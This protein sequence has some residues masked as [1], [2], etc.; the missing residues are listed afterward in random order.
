MQTNYKMYSF[1]PDEQFK[2]KDPVLNEKYQDMKA[3]IVRANVSEGVTSY[4]NVD[5]V[6]LG[7]N[8]EL[9]IGNQ[10][11]NEGY[12]QLKNQF[13]EN[14]IKLDTHLDTQ[15]VAESPTSTKRIILKVL[16]PGGKGK[17]FKPTAGV[18]L[19]GENPHLLI[20]QNYS[21]HVE[22]MSKVTIKEQVC[23]E[24]EA[25]VTPN[26]DFKNNESAGAA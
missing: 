24:L 4:R 11:D 15:L 13:L 20:D 8:K 10:I 25:K 18:F 3:A 6:E 5:P 2:D 12:N 7:F 17:T 9:I 23:V 21:L 26:L 22:K 19:D 14:N 16:T 1:W